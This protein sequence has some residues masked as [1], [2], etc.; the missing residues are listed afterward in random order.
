[1]PANSANTWESRVRCQNPNLL[2]ADVLAFLEP[3]F[4]GDLAA[5][6]LE[7]TPLHSH[8]PLTEFEPQYRFEGIDG[9]ARVMFIVQEELRCLHCISLPIGSTFTSIEADEFD[10]A[11][12]QKAARSDRQL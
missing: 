1:M 9:M 4:V 8:K 3:V 10:S 5:L 2:V 12:A 11:I 7:N 6:N